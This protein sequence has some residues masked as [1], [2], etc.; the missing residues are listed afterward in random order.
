MAA[1]AK[2][3]AGSKDGIEVTSAG[4]EGGAH[5]AGSNE[6]V[7]GDGVLRLL[8]GD[9]SGAEPADQGGD[10]LDDGA[11]KDGDSEVGGADVV[12]GG[13]RAADVSLGDLNTPE[14]L[15]QT[16]DSHASD[17]LGDSPDNGL[18]LGHVPLHAGLEV[19]VRTGS[20]VSP[21]EGP[22]DGRQEQV[23]AVCSQAI[24]ISNWGKVRRFN[25]QQLGYLFMFFIYN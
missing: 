12:H 9:E 15:N 11:V 16:E 18:L 25:N 1:A 21:V 14:D 8:H 20:G 6:A 23:E 10:S 17:D 5:H 22:P 19:I 2:L 24:V 13:V 3:E 7:D 4:G